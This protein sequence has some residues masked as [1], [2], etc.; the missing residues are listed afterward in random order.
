MKFTIE[1][2]EKLCKKKPCQPPE[3][4][5]S[6]RKKEIGERN[7]YCLQAVFFHEDQTRGKM[8]LILVKLRLFI[9]PR[10]FR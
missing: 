1:D 9:L 2:E 5:L 10:I 6:E 8:A 3:S 4:V 7:R